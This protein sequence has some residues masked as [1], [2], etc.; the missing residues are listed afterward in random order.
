M[1]KTGVDVIKVASEV[2][3]KASE[4][5]EVISKQATIAGGVISE[6]ASKAGVVIADQAQIAGGIIKENA[7]IAGGVIKEQASIAGEQINKVIHENIPDEKIP[8]I[9]KLPEMPDMSSELHTCSCWL[10]MAQD[11]I[12]K[13]LNIAYE[14]LA[15]KYDH[16][17]LHDLES[18][19]QHLHLKTC[20]ASQVGHQPYMWT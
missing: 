19:S 8:T 6:Q 14:F 2:G 13:Y 17:E 20:A 3:K 9:P 18:G 7:Q 5:G 11:F 15:D 12:V 4:A 10:H 1:E 16:F